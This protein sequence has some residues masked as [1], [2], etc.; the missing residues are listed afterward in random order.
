MNHSRQHGLRFFSKS[1]SISHVVGDGHWPHTHRR[2]SQ[3]FTLNSDS[4]RSFVFEGDQNTV[5]S[6]EN[7]DGKRQNYPRQRLLRLIICVFNWLQSAT[8]NENGSGSGIRMDQRRRERANEHPTWP[9]G[10]GAVVVVAFDILSQ[11]AGYSYIYLCMCSAEIRPRPPSISIHGLYGTVSLSSRQ[12]VYSLGFAASAVI[13]NML[14]RR[15]LVTVLGDPKCTA[16]PSSSTFL[17]VP[18]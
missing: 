17:V 14:A 7:E 4:G 10:R 8:V 16:V 18:N 11:L 2:S 12:A 3:I 5:L 9:V 15:D 1:S 13:I 6:Y